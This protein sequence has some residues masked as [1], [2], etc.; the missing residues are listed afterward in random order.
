MIGEKM[1][2]YVLSL[3]W[4]KRSVTTGQQQN[5]PAVRVDKMCVWKGKG[6]F[7]KVIISSKTCL[8]KNTAKYHFCSSFC[9]A[10]EAGSGR[11]KTY[12]LEGQ[13]E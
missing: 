12:S 3:T 2:H 13:G 8:S 6:Q 10:G 7:S 4:L 9:R 1:F 5:P 11:A